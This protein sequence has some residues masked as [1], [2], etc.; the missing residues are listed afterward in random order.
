[1]QEMVQFG[2]LF[3]PGMIGK[4]R[5]RNR[6]IMPAM[7]K[8][9]ANRDG[10]VTQ[11]YIDYL[12]A[13]AKGGVGLIIVEAT[14]VDPRGKGRVFQLGAY[15]DRLIPGLKQMAETVH[16][17]GAKIALE[18]HHAG[19]ETSSVTTGIQPLSASPV[20]CLPSGGDIPRE[21][22]IPEINE[23]VKKFADAA[24]RSKEAG[25][26]LVEIHGAHG[27]LLAQFLSPYT[28]KRT[29]DYGG[30]FEKRMRFPLEVVKAVRKA[31]G[32]DFPIA[33]RLSADEYIDGGLTLEETVPFAQRL[34]EEGVNLIDVSAGI[35]ETGF[36]FVGLMYFP[37]GYM[38]H[39]AEAIKRAIDIPVSTAGR[40]NDPVFAENILKEGRA[41]FVNLGRALHAD[42]EFPQKARE[43]RIDDICKCIACNQGCT[44]ILGTMAPIFCAI[45]PLVS[46]EREYEIKRATKK[47]RVVVTGGG[48]SGMEAARVAALRGHEVLLYEKEKELGGQ[49]RYACRALFKGEMEQVIRYLSNQIKKAG[50]KVN[51]GQDLDQETIHKMK[52][53]TVVIAT[54]ATP[55]WPPIPGVEKGH[56]YTYLDILG[57]KVSAGK[58]VAVIG[59]KLIGC[60]IAEYILDKGGEVI[61]LE[62]TGVFCEDAGPRMKWLLMERLD[63][64]PKLD[65]RLKTNVEK[66]NDSSIVIQKDGKIEEINGVDTVVLALG[67]TSNNVL[68][69]ELKRMSKVSEIY[70]VGDCVIPRKMT[71][72]IYEGFMVGFKI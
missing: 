41:D 60:E 70:T 7:E 71:E 68:A 30:T 53:D 58:K 54:G 69:D 37:L 67:A 29:D 47:K 56:V 51:L 25:F 46:R 5:I 17:Y 45:N 63:E 31:V 39:L 1:M 49:I 20:P 8:N 61:L 9:Y 32:E 14:Y 43:G 65:K 44:D 72:A 66:I 59:G 62:A 10:S 24:R 34:E 36:I 33:Y 52:P 26:D 57:G 28:N 38:V 64:Y 13:R 40:I 6:I 3:E 48:P 15:D 55:Y 21:M 19:R 16:Q 50:V 23:M 42:P 12:V 35:Y 11:R 27:Y 18:L 22:T 2:K 4:V